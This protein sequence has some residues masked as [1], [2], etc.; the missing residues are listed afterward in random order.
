MRRCTATVTSRCD[1]TLFTPWNKI[2]FK[3]GLIPQG[4]GM[5]PP[6]DGDDIIIADYKWNQTVVTPAAQKVH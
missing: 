4:T 1:Y 2:Q 3:P 5:T 6:A